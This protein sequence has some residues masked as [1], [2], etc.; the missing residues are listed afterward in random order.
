[1][2]GGGKSHITANIKEIF[3][4]FG[5]V[6]QFFVWV[7]RFMKCNILVQ[8]RLW[9]TSSVTLILDMIIWAVIG[10]SDDEFNFRSTVCIRF[11]CLLMTFLV[12]V[13]QLIFYHHF[14]IP[15]PSWL[16]WHLKVIAFECYYDACRCYV[17]GNA[18]NHSISFFC[19]FGARVLHR[20]GFDI[21]DF[22]VASMGQ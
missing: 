22:V 2:K 16:S 4:G 9:S 3:V 18:G 14:T 21:T 20:V 1:M 17:F 13:E 7:E 11:R 10:I 15:V 5:K 8:R 19:V 12:V 6:S